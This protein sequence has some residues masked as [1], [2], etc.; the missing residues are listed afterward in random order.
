MVDSN[1]VIEGTVKFRDGKKWKSR[2]CVMRKLSPV[3]DCLHLQLY[4]DSKERYKQGQ[5]KASLSLQHFLA[6]ETG[7]TLD[8]ESNTIAIICQDVTVILAFDTRERLMQWQVK[9]SSNLG[10]DVQF[11]IQMSSA[12]PRAKIAAGPARLHVQEQRFCLTSGVPPRLLGF[13]DIS[14]LRRYGVVEGRFVFEGGSRCGKGEGVHVCVT[15]QGDEITRTFQMA[16]QGKVATRRRPRNVSAA[17]SPRR[18]RQPTDV[19]SA[20]ALQQ[21]LLAAE[22]AAA[23]PN[24]SG[25]CCGLCQHDACALSR[26]PST[27]NLVCH[28]RLHGT[29]EGDPPMWMSTETTPVGCGGGGQLQLELDSNYGCGDA[30]SVSDLSSDQHYCWPPAAGHGALTPATGLDRCVSCMSKLGAM[31]RSSTATTY[32]NTPAQ[33]FSPAWTMEPPAELEEPLPPQQQPPPPP[34]GSSQSEYCVPRPRL[35]SPTSSSSTAPTSAAAPPASGQATAGSHPPQPPCR[36]CQCCPPK[37]AE[38]GDRAASPPGGCKARLRP[39]PLVATHLPQQPARRQCSCSVL[40]TTVAVI[41]HHSAAVDPS[42]LYDTPKALL[43]GPPLRDDAGETYDTPRQVRERLAMTDHY[44]VPAS[45]RP[46]SCPCHRVLSWVRLPYCRRGS[47]VD[48]SATQVPIT[49]V[50]LSG[51]G[52]MPVVNQRGEIAIYA[53]VDKS[54]KTNKRLREAAVSSTTQDGIAPAALPMAEQQGSKADPDVNNYVNVDGGVCQEDNTDGNSTI[55]SFDATNYENIDFAH[56]L[57]YYENSR[58][59]LSKVSLVA[60]SGDQNSSDSALDDGVRNGMTSSGEGAVTFCAKCG[61]ECPDA[62]SDHPENQNGSKVNS[63]ASLATCEGKVTKPDVEDDYLMMEPTKNGRAGESGNTLEA[64]SGT[65]NGSFPG[66]LP[67]SPIT[68]VNSSSNKIETLK[69]QV[70]HNSLNCPS[71]EKSVSVPSL[72]TGEM[73]R[74]VRRCDFSCQRV[75]C[76]STVTVVHHQHVFHQHQHYNGDS[77]RRHLLT[78]SEEARHRGSFAYRKRSSSADSSRYLDEFDEHDGGEHDRPISTSQS[79]FCIPAAQDEPS[80]TP[81]VPPKSSALTKQTASVVCGD[82]S[83]A[84][85]VVS[86]LSGIVNVTS[87]QEVLPKVHSAK[88]ES[89]VVVE[90]AVEVTECST[91]ESADSPAAVSDAPAVAVPPVG[92]APRVRRSSSLAQAAGNRDSSSSSDSGVSTCS[93]LLLVRPAAA[94]TTTAARDFELPLTT[95]LSSRKHQQQRLLDQLDGEA[96][97]HASLPRRSKSVDPLRDISFQ[98]HRDRAR[99]APKS[100]SAEAE[101]PVCLKNRGFQS[102]GGDSAIVVPYPDSRSTSSGTS[103]M[104]DYI[105]TLSLSSHSSSDVTESIRLGRQATTMLRPRSGKEYQPINQ[106]ILERDVALN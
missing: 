89:R 75:V 81:P 37:T 48:H 45:A 14:Q 38:G 29:G 43:P 99:D 18:H 56:S 39:L 19:I 96:C 28:C 5:T 1:T 100:T 64:V 55:P 15:D 41:E 57:E 66:Y 8:K 69:L 25:A 94:A 95:A 16:A 24:G 86:P 17:S 21:R 4:R 88:R 102:P 42:A 74:C 47:G 73:E 11:L 65:T 53:T 98:F 31:S 83:K 71:V 80:Q 61:H 106:S 49:R 52:K 60:Q 92:L 68:S 97:L 67:M 72:L 33:P 6:I 54:K 34:P 62:I 101:V 40:R 36:C 50:P 27:E 44:D 7:F 105:E 2:W 32:P 63:S 10:E 103:D 51:Q 35:L 93:S 87:E 59:I 82:S 3:A 12:P 30:G 23:P 84:E 13:W 76:G 20:E 85:G 9:I 58:D 79:N 70:D 26:Q 104:S 78:P 46:A 77:L 22:G 91:M 90:P